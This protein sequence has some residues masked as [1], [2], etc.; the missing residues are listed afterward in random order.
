MLVTW[1]FEKQFGPPRAAG[2]MWSNCGEL[3]P[4][5]T[6]RLWWVSITAPLVVPPFMIEEDFP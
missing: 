2:T 4:P 3:L 5:P 1:A 6:I